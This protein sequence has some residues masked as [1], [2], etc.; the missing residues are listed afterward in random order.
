MGRAP[1]GYINRSKEDGR[2]YIA[3]KEPEASSMRWAFNEIAKGVFAADQ[4]QQKMNSQ[5][6]TKL[7]RS[8]F[9]VAIRN[10]LYCGKIF[11]AK[12]KDE[13]SCFVQGQHEPLISEE[14]FNKVQLVLDGNKRVV[15]PNVKIRSDA[16]L[17]LRGSWFA[18]IVVET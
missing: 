17:P 1:F 2:K 13:E 14:L 12:F 6:L 10:P 4:V 18:Q 15:R 9:H 16:N 3:F 11:I 5:S 7:S 8:A